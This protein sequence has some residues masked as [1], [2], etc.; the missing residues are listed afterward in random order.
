MFFCFYTTMNDGPCSYERFYLSFASSIWFQ[1]EPYFVTA[2]TIT[3]NTY[4]ARALLFVSLKIQFILWRFK[5][6]FVK[7]FTFHRVF[8]S[9]GSICLCHVNLYVSYGRV[10]V[11]LWQLPKNQFSKCFFHLYFV[12]LNALDANKNCM[13]YNS[14]LIQ[15]HYAII[16]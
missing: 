13:I 9:A 8:F 7:L 4:C 16:R 11:V 14:K 3:S 15:Q 12:R 6:C 2:N 10:F 5:G 1:G